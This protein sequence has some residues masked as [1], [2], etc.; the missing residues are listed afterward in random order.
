[1]IRLLAP[2]LLLLAP[3][4][5]LLAATAPASARTIAIVNGKIVT[6]GPAGTVEGGTVIVRD[7]KIVSVAKGGAVP[8][9]AEVIDA[10]GKWVT[11]GLFDSS[12]QLGLVELVAFANAN[13]ASA[14]G[15]RYSAAFDVQFGLSAGITSLAVARSQGITRAAAVPAAGAHIFSGFGALVTM[16]P[17]D[18]I[19]LRS[20]AFQFVELGTTGATNAGGARGAA[21][22]EFLDALRM[23]KAGAEPA[24]SEKALKQADLEAI[25]PVVEGI[26]PLMVHVER[27]SDILQVLALRSSYPRLRPILFGAAEGWMVARE[28]AEARIPVILCPFVSLPSSFETLAA[29]RRNAAILGEAGVTLAFMPAPKPDVPMVGQLRQGAGIAVAYG[30]SWEDALRAVTLGPAEIFGVGAQLGSLDVGKTAD[31]V[32]WNGDPLELSSYAE[33]VLIGGRT[34]SL[35]T[36]QDELRDRY[37]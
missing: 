23:A 11:P 9:D 6:M 5:L 31:L 20:R 14:R 13:D 35:I 15:S 17:Q 26:V 19:L 33:K 34:A 36:R 37:R 21:W 7:G 4:L 3:L 28:I 2:L 25:R 8:A 18:P 1:M 22:I 27:A 29:T 32:V 16:K 30:L 12:S 10:K 24:Y